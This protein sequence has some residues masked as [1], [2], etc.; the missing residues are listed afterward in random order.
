M[1]KTLLNKATEPAQLI[2]EFKNPK[3]DDVLVHVKSEGKD[4]AYNT[5]EIDAIL[6]AYPKA[7]AYTDINESPSALTF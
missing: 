5:K 6:T 7:E 2:S 3:L 1:R 4:L